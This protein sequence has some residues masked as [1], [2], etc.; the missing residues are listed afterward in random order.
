MQKS[1]SFSSISEIEILNKH[2]LNEELNYKKKFMKD[3]NF[4][5]YKKRSSTEKPLWLQFRTTLPY[6]TKFEKARILGARALQLSMGAP[7]TIKT[8]SET[9]VLELAA[10]E[11]VERKI[12]ITIR[13]YL[14]NGKYEDWRVDELIIE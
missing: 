1:S 7:L 6:L 5:F 13:R 4:S 10:K 2:V 14:P 9:D 11:L 3:K 8:N 12:P